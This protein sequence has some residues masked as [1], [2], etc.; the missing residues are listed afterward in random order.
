MKQYKGH[1]VYGVA[2]AAPEHRWCSLG[3][4]LIGT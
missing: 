3:L 2:I 1:P 4:V